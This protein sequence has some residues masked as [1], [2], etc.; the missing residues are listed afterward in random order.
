MMKYKVY[1]IDG[2]KM[3][4]SDLRIVEASRI[5]KVKIRKLLV[6]WKKLEEK[7]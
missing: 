3:K 7:K 2:S 6:F 4:V 5:K 1:F